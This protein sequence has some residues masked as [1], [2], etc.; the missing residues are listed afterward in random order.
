MSQLHSLCKTLLV[1]AVSFRRNFLVPLSLCFLLELR[2]PVSWAMASHQISGPS[3]NSPAIER[4]QEHWM[5]HVSP[6]AK[7]TSRRSSP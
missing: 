7:H 4:V 6:K 3:V 2:F 5:T 1:T